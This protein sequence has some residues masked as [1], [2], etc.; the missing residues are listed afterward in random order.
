MANKKEIKPPTKKE[1]AAITIGNIARSTAD[2][3]A[4]GLYRLMETKEHRQLREATETISHYVSWYLMQDNDFMDQIVP[5]K[6]F[7]KDVRLQKALEVKGISEEKW[8]QDSEALLHVAPILG[9]KKDKYYQNTPDYNEMCYNHQYHNKLRQSLTFFSISKEE[10]IKYGIKV[11]TIY[12]LFEEDEQ[13]S[14]TMLNGR[15]L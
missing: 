6:D 8:L 14:I 5:K 10:W 15:K 7:D 4:G 9:L 3:I 13:L 2:T 1:K 12:D 11:L